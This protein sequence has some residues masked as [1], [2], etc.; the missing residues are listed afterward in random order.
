MKQIKLHA[1][2]WQ[3]C[4]KWLL[5]NFFLKALLVFLRDKFSRAPLIRYFGSYVPLDT[6]RKL[7]VHKTFSKRL[8]PL[9]NVLC[10]FS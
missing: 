1:L 3:H 10:T 9:L 6:G 2:Q 4:G 5:Q 8:G 7:N